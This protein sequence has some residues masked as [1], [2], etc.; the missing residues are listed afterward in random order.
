MDTNAECVAKKKLFLRGKLKDLKLM[1][2]CTCG[3]SFLL[4][5]INILNPADTSWVQIRITVYQ[6][7]TSFNLLRQLWSNNGK[8]LDN[9]SKVVLQLKFDDRQSL[10]TT[11]GFYPHP[12][13]TTH[14]YHP[15]HLHT[16]HDIKLHHRLCQFTDVNQYQALKSW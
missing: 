11:H 13:T 2:R 12:K 9:P 15:R 8:S 10:P 7:K 6:D 4:L 5:F 14:P 16:T 3:N 1:K